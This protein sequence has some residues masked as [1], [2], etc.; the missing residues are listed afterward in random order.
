MNVFFFGYFSENCSSKVIFQNFLKM[1]TTNL[2]IWYGYK[3]YFKSWVKRPKSKKNV[4][5]AR[6]KA[7]EFVLTYD[8]S[9]F[10]KELWI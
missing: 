5:H 9:L 4:K 8:V 10:K 1:S 2:D 3:Y 7:D 6:F